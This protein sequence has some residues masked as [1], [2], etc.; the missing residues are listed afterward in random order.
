MSRTQGNS[1]QLCLGLFGECG[2]GIV[3]GLDPSLRSTGYAIVQITPNQIRV[4]EL[5]TIRCS[6][7][8]LRSQ[9]LA[10]L[11]QQLRLLVA[12]FHPQACAVE[13]LIYAR[14]QR[15]ALVLGEARGVSLS[16]MAE[17]G[18]PIFEL[19]PRKV[20]QAV[21]G[22]GAATKEAVARVLR[23]MLALQDL[24]P[25]DAADALA[26]A[27]AFIHQAGRHYN[28]FVEPL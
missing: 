22:Y 15:T 20:K 24:K 18:V 19:A 27:I 10:H 3:L 4:Q 23:H 12:Q 6:P 17:A 7:S 8:W 14:N 28:C 21:T 26:V 13:G 9:C 2:P 1:W 25:G 5:G 16:V 11:A